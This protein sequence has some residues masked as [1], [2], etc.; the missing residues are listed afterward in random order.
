MTTVQ[1]P[2]EIAQEYEARAR[3]AGRDLMAYIREV[4]IEKLEDIGDIE[5]AEER[6][7]N[8]GETLSLEEVKKNL[9]LDD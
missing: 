2:D 7:R 1:I 6:L 4:L 5:L 8:P 3:A 9:G